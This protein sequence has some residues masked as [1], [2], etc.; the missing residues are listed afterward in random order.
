[1][2]I[3]FNCAC[4]N[5]TFRLKNHPENNKQNGVLCGFSGML[6]SFHTS[7]S[8]GNELTLRTAVIHQGWGRNNVRHNRGGMW[9]RRY[10]GLA[11]NRK[12]ASSILVRAPPS[13]VMRCPWARRL[14]TTVCVWVLQCFEWPLVRKVLYKGS[15]FTIY[16]LFCCA[17]VAMVSVF[18]APRWCYCELHSDKVQSSEVT[19]LSFPRSHR[20]KF[21][22][23]GVW[24]VLLWHH[25]HTRHW[26]SLVA[27]SSS[28][29]P[30]CRC[31]RPKQAPQP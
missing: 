19:L 18:P 24:S 30:Q 23:F 13:W 31:S 6:T 11:G 14:T 20:V 10:S 28:V 16:H 22:L 15:P 26:I 4:F 7:G 5:H 17:M 21:L 8:R 27:F 12:V 9:L 3:Y 2:L 1:M 25:L 29:L